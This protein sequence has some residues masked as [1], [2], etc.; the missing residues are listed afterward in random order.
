MGWV[1]GVRHNLRPQIPHMLLLLK[2]Q[3][4]HFGAPDELTNTLR[5]SNPTGLVGSPY[6]RVFPTKYVGCIRNV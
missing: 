2:D 4:C 5:I 6:G 1:M 3:L